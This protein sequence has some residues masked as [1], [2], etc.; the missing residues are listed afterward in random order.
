[1]DRAQ[2]NACMGD[3]MRGKKLTPDER[4][5]AFCVASKVCSGKAGSEEEARKIC[6]I[7]KP[8]KQ[9]KAKRKVKVKSCEDDVLADVQCMLDYFEREQTYKKLLNVNTVGQE[10]ATALMECRCGKNEQTD[11][12]E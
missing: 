10:V 2:Y 1:M 5:T 12:S 6:S 11:T 9:P 3:A 4:K 8:P 7:P